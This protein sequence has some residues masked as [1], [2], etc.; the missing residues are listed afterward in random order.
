M[1]F[2]RDVFLNFIKLITWLKKFHHYAPQR[3]IIFF[4]AAFQFRFVRRRF[5]I[6]SSLICFLGIM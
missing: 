2:Q 3:E 6:S 5:L 4:A 1:K